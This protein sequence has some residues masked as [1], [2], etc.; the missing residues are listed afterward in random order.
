VPYA[1]LHCHSNFSFL[2]GASE[3]EDL[4]EQAA[5]LGLDA[6][7]LTDHDGMYGAVRFA[8]AAKDLGVRT[9]YGA[10]LS[11]GLSAPQNGEPD[12]DGTHLLC[13]AR[14]L[15]G[16]RRLCRVISHAQLAGGEKGRPA[17]DLDEVVGELRGHVVVLTSCRKGHVRRSTRNDALAALAT[18]KG[19]STVATNGV[20]YARPEDAPVAEAMAAVRARRG[21]EELEGWLPA[22][23]VAFLRSGQEMTA[24]LGSR[25]PGR[26]SGRR[27][28]GGV[29]LRPRTRRPQ[30]AAVPGTGRARRGLLS[31]A[32]DVGG[33]GPPL[34]WPRA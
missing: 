4:V 29:R 9:V 14:G 27:C 32:V 30:P 10:E 12:P 2:N 8:E 33:R 28:W 18:E 23:G 34:Q 13:L 11:L 3:P 31:A 7:A 26:C 19:L 16:Y 24:L 15:E 25:Y 6:L 5:R 17:Y 20:H 1:E 21:L 22:A